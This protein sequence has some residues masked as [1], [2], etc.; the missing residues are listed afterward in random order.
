[1]C[2]CGG[3][4]EHVTSRVSV[5]VFYFQKNLKLCCKYAWNVLRFQGLLCACLHHA[6]WQ[7]LSI[8]LS[9][10]PMACTESLLLDLVSFPLLVYS[11]PH[12]PDRR[13]KPNMNQFS[14]TSSFAANYTG[15]VTAVG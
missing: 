7:S 12:I 13:E 14:Q 2:V 15:V 1:M 9:T 3:L 6:P 10:V 4:H 5:G 11:L 8:A